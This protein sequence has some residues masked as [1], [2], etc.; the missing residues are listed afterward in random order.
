MILMRGVRKEL[1]GKRSEGSDE[2]KRGL[3]DG[4][5]MWRTKCDDGGYRMSH[6]V[7]KLSAMSGQKD[8]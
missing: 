7:E 1:I 5:M 4:E 2:M 8:A 3:L 6:G